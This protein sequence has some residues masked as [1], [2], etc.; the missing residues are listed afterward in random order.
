LGSGTSVQ[1]VDN[2][3][4]ALATLEVL[5]AEDRFALGGILDLKQLLIFMKNKRFQKHQ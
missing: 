2:A 1:D 5:N 4:T 3:S